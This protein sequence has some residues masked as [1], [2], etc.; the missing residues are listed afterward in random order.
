[1]IAGR[2]A[3]VLFACT[4]L[5]RPLLAQEHPLPP[6][7]PFL[8]EVRA[9]LQPDDA[10]SSAYTYT[11]TERRVKLDGAGR[12][13]RESVTVAESYPGLGPGE[14]RWRRVIERDG[15]RVAEA[16]LQ[17]KDAERQ[18]QAEE[19]ARRLQ[20]AGERAKMTRERE[21]E[22]REEREAVDDVF[23]V[24]DVAMV[25]R[26]VVD[27]H[28]TV[29]VSLTPKPRAAPRTR[30]GKWMHGFKGRAWISESDYE[31]VRLDV[32]AV[33]DL[34]F[35]LGLVA[36]LHKGA[37]MTFTRRKINGE[38]WLPARVQYTMS[39]RVLLL[40]RLR[41]GGTLEISNYRRFSVDTETSIA[42][43]Q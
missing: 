21:K 41:E 1:V 33:K 35:A 9:R 19:Y 3:F 22:L 28:G 40:K 17:K 37:T 5:C 15:R 29:V 32:E 8:K 6:L 27:G 38:E 7:E 12:P 43:P 16:E 23:R 31:L 13:R 4:L 39:A 30:E 42:A 20:S 34:S 24:F 36:R 11:I 10:R 18:K 25:G 26:E 14:S 2:V